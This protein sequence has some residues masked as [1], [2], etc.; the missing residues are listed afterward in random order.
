MTDFLLSKR[1]LM[2]IMLPM[3]QGFILMIATL[4]EGSLSGRDTPMCMTD[5]KETVEI[6]IACSLSSIVTP[7]EEGVEEE[8]AVRLQCPCHGT[9]RRPRVTASA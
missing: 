8:A 6:T 3:Q 1:E 7:E 9:L 4:P 2:E 5:C